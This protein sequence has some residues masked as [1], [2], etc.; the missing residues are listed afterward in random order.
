MISTT[1]QI[2]PIIEGILL[3]GCFNL[4]IIVIVANL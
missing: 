4:Y 1:I 3:G 2:I